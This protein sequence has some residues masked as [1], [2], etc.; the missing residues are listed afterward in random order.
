MKKYITPILYIGTVLMLFYT[1]FD[2][3]SRVKTVPVL[4]QQVDSLNVELFN[5]QVQ[6]GRY[7]TTTE[8]FLKS[9]YPKVYE[10][11]KTYLDHETE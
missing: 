5:E 6:T 10:E 1:L 4:E 11:Y 9:K 3:R 2:L 7:E 8:E